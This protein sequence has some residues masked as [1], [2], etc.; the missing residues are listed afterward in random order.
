MRFGT[1][2]FFVCLPACWIALVG[3]N[4]VADE[5]VLFDDMPVVLT[6]ARLRQPQAQAPAAVTIIDRDTIRLS[7]ARNLPELLRV[8]PGFQIGFSYGHTATVSYH[9]MADEWARRLQVL[10]DGRS[11]YEPSFARIQWLEMPVA[12][13]NIQRIEITRGPNSALYGANSFNAVIN[14][15]TLTP[16][17]ADGVTVSSKQGEKGIRDQLLQLATSITKNH[18]IRA[19]LGSRGDHGFDETRSSDPRYDSYRADFANARLDGI[20][21]ETSHYDVQFG[22]KSGF[23]QIQWLDP[24]EVEPTHDIKNNNAFVL[25]HLYHERGDDHQWRWQFYW[26]ENNNREQW[27]TCPPR[28]FLSNE[29]AALFQA[30]RNYTLDLIDAL[31]LG[32]PPPSPPS[33]EI[34]ALLPPLFARLPDDGNRTACGIGNQDI[35]EQRFDLELQDTWQINDQWRMVS[36]VSLRHD[37]AYSET[38]L[39]GKQHNNLLRVFANTEYHLTPTVVFNGGA[40]VEHDDIVGT[41]LSPRVAANWTVDQHHTLRAIYVEATRTP[42]MF[43]ESGQFGYTVRV[44]Q[45]PVNGSDDFARFFQTSMAPGGLDPE[46]IRSRE[47]GVYGHYFSSQFSWDLKLFSDA[48]RDLVA[49]YSTLERFD[50]NNSG[51]ADID[52]QEL[53]LQ[54]RPTAQWRMQLAYS[55]LQL[56]GETHRF[57]R[58]STPEET[59]SFML[60]WLSPLG[61]ELSVSYYDMNDYYDAHYQL[62]SSRLAKQWALSSRSDFTLALESRIRLDDQWLFD[63][64]NIDASHHHHWLSASFHF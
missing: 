36:G 33:A 14:I 4:A 37:D 42:D 61:L 50:L 53:E 43:E 28:V 32:A 48:Y 39:S 24:Y 9:G 19:T 41:S 8:V 64:D 3:N 54:W 59:S 45:T 29:L 2:S 16:K 27:A 35:H 22:V 1:A 34:A 10:I 15:I 38:Y 47:L 40:M 55:R 46:R 52:G 18:D 5:D 56:G 20:I 6:T 11:I 63:R 58:R 25:T 49:G 44:L 31:T 23:K 26:N 17:E 62:V 12:L 13:E 7:G 60:A 30:D 57:M 51:R 21:N